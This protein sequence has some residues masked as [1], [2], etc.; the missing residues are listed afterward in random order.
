MRI[1][2]VKLRNYRGVL[3]CEVSFPADGVTIVEGPNEVGKTSLAQAVRM[4]FEYRDDSQSRTVRSVKPVGRDEGA[5]VEIEVSTGPYRFV[6][7]KRWHRQKRTTLHVLEP[8]PEQLSGREAHERVQAML[9]ETLDRDLWSALSLDQGEALQQASLATASLGKAL[10]LA[11]GSDHAGDQE[12]DLWERINDERLRYATPTGQV[13]GERAALAREVEGAEQEVATV[14]ARL[15]ALDV[16]TEE[17]EWLEGEAIELARSQAEADRSAAELTQRAAA[18]DARRANVRQLTAEWQA[19][20]ATLATAQQVAERR[21]ELLGA[22]ESSAAIHTAHEDDVRRSAPARTAAEAQCEAALARLREARDAAQAAEAEQRRTADDE[23]HRRHEIEISLFTER[24]ERVLE[25]QARR[26]TAHEVLDR[27]TVTAALVAEIEEAHLDLARAEAAAASGAVAVEITGLGAPAV[28]LDGEL[29]A[30]AEGAVLERAV[31]DVGQF[32]VP[33]ALRLV[34]RAGAE[35]RALA[36]RHRDAE[37]RFG[38]LCRRGGVRDLTEARAALAERAEAERA[39]T[40][41][42]AAIEENLRDL[43][44]DE[45]AQKIERLGA[46]LAR[47]R[48]TRPAEP[49]LPADHGAAQLAAEAATTALEVR[50]AELTEAAAE[51]DAATDAMS[52]IDLGDAGLGAL[53]EQSRIALDQAEQSLQRARAPRSDAEVLLGLETA[54]A[55]EADAR[56]RKAAADAA[57]AA[58]DPDTLDALLDNARGAKARAAQQVRRNDERQRTLRA[59]LEVQGDQGL[60]L[61]LDDALTTL[62]HLRREHQRVEQRAAAAELLHATFAARRA[63]ARHRYVAPFR[64]RIEQLGRI[65]YGPSLQIELDDDLSIARRTLD[66]VTCDFDQLS[67]G[68]QEQLGIISR[69]ACAAIVSGD[70]GAPVVFDDALGW[71][72]PRRL[73]TMGAAIAVAG[74]SCQVIV[75]T[76]TPGRYASVGHA[77]VVQL[78]NQ[79]TGLAGDRD[80]LAVPGQ[81]ESDMPESA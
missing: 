7:A 5:E 27:A 14:E 63:E 23:A 55:D 32:E 50:R 54:V 46:R 3:E 2:R 40:E 79:A 20:A 71:T 29:V 13:K 10:D 69:L 22:V 65:V 12:S 51:A 77:T 8:R 21:Q 45:L 59:Q 61:Q 52:S 37:D 56:A 43:T 28:E 19:A 39:Q 24:H 15:R 17:V 53:L 64:D 81:S 72:D 58:E 49:P 25:A 68:A 73:E 78:P 34:I 80:S 47:S 66:G 26:R 48:G 36:D 76:C 16:A 31:T 42:T 75:L 1:H 4:I 67:T 57:L 74:R 38:E 70:G 30:L 62:G 11:S 18:V 35:A 9:D 41:A 33:G 60:A 44:L 6:Y